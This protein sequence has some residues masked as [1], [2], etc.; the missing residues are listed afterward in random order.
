MSSVVWRG[1][2]A[3][4]VTPSNLI[5]SLLT[6]DICQCQE[7]GEKSFGEGDT[8]LGVGMMGAKNE[9]ALEWQELWSAVNGEPKY[10]SKYGHRKHAI[11]SVSSAGCVR[12]SIPINDL[13]DIG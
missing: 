9:I 6:D 8:R 2:I 12:Y 1:L 10:Q 5:Y 4:V 7:L 11:G 13:H 3:S